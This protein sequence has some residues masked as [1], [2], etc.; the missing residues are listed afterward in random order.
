MKYHGPGSLLQ[1]M[2]VSPGS[3]ACIHLG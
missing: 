3:S 2:P 1:L